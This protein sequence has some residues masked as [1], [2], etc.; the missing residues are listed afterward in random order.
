MTDETSEDLVFVTKSV[1]VTTGETL[2]SPFSNRCGQ[3]NIFPSFAVGSSAWESNPV[4]VRLQNFL[5][6]VLYNTVR[7]LV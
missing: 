6:L 1:T 2:E 5:V 4:S 3:K 7:I